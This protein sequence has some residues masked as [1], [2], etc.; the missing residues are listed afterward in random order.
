MGRSCAAMAPL[1][2]RAP[3]RRPS[4]RLIGT[5][6]G[7]RAALRT[8]SEH[9]QSNAGRCSDNRTHSVPTTTRPQCTP[10][11]PQA[12]GNFSVSP[13]AGDPPPPQD[14]GWVRRGVPAPWSHGCLYGAAPNLRRSERAA[15]AG[16]KTTRAKR[17]QRQDG[18]PDARELRL[19]PNAR[20]AT[21]FVFSSRSASQRRSKRG[22]PFWMLIGSG[23]PMWHTAPIQ[24]MIL[25]EHLAGEAPLLDLP[26]LRQAA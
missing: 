14:R 16:T 19:R 20:R 5:R 23:T 22:R 9:R 6:A 4:G 13:S 2:L 24:E 3:E 11:P 26:L 25:R 8:A 10:T 18:E 1:G 21:R 17:R 7:T 15:T 12:K